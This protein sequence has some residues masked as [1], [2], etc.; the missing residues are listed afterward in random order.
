VPELLV[1]ALNPYEV[2]ALARYL[3]HVQRTTPVEVPD[4]PLDRAINTVCDAA[5]TVINDD[6]AGRHA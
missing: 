3:D 5:A 1:I 6:R 2:C 4:G